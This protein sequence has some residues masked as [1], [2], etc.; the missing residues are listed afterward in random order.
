MEGYRLI[1]FA[2]Y[3][4]GTSMVHVSPTCTITQP[5]YLLAFQPIMVHGDIFSVLH[6][7]PRHLVDVSAENLFKRLNMLYSNACSHYLT[8]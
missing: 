7:K 6:K 1:E 4:Y 8:V 5:L 2:W 3:M